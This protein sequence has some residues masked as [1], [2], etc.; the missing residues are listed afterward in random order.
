MNP[1]KQ[2]ELQAFALRVRERIIPMAT[3]GGCFLGAS[4]SAV[5]L[6]TYLYTSFLHIEKSNLDDPKRDYLF[7]SKGHDVPALYGIFAELGWIESNRLE[8]HLSTSDHIYWHPNRHIPGVEFH[9]GSLGQLPAVAIGV[10][11]DMKISKT[12]NRVVCVMG[13]GELNEGSCWEAFL[14]A[15]AHKLSNLIFVIDRNQFQAN[16]AT[17]DLI[18]LEPLVDKFVAFGMHTQRVNGHDFAQLAEAFEQTNQVPGPHV[19]ICD[20]VRG[21][22]LPSIEARSDR[23]FCNF[24]EVEIQSL[25]DELH[26]LSQATLTAETLVVR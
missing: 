19:I 9:S 20:T 22:G 16:M 23:W 11:M 14:V 21:K 2:T 12:A 26:Q 25:M 5:D 15:N 6:L 18:P 17:E 1:T 8:N 3:D 10:A 7:L 13:D 4:L 24:S